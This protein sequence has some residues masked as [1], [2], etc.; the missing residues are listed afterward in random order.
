MNFK[1]SLHF[2]LV[3]LFCFQCD[4]NDAKCDASKHKNNTYEIT[5][6]V[7]AHAGGL[8]YD[9]YVTGNTRVYKWY[10]TTT[11]VCIYDLIQVNVA[12]KTF[13]PYNP[14][15]F[16]ILAKEEHNIPITTTPIPL[17]DDNSLLIGTA[18][19][20]LLPSFVVGNGSFDSVVEI[21]FPTSGN[22]DQDVL[23]L[24]SKIK[25]IKFI[26]KYSGN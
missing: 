14:A 8:T 10:R 1:S 20:N 16:S 25:Y 4:E 22:A 21:S 26:L 17:F 12:V 9:T 24:L 5:A 19:V 15:E 18:T 2:M 7:N 11:D 6:P 13:D 3:S 23:F